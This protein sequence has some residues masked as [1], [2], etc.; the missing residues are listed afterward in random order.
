[1]RMDRPVVMAPSMDGFVPRDPR[2]TSGYAIASES[3]VE[4][5]Q[6]LVIERSDYADPFEDLVFQP[7]R[8]G[9]TNRRP[10]DRK[11]VQ[12][13]PQTQTQ[14]PTQAQVQ[15]TRRHAAAEAISRPSLIMA[16]ISIALFAGG[17]LLLVVS[18]ILAALGVSQMAGT[19]GPAGFAALALGCLAL[20][21]A[22]VMERHHERSNGSLD[23]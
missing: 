21:L 8:K 11:P 15:T 13:E 14:T 9:L 10:L 19:A 3:R 23:R 1:M 22:G 5:A 12:D 18:A 17:G 2:I 20:F 6:G 7:L 4:T 16:K